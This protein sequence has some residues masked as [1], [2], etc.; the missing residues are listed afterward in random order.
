[1]N[2]PMA[3]I[4]SKRALRLWAAI[5]AVV[6]CGCATQT[7]NK[8]PGGELQAPSA[9]QTISKISTSQESETV[10]VTLAADQKLAYTAIK[11]A[12]PLAVVLYFPETRVD[13]VARLRR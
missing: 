7:A 3:N 9:K 5:L 10:T 4:F 2:Y 13:Q 6:F 8:T 11:Q 1:M 12:K